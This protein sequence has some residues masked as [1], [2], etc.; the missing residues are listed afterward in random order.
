MIK[1]APPGNNTKPTSAGQ[2]NGHTTI[3]HEEQEKLDREKSILRGDV[4]K[5]YEAR[6]EREKQMREKQKKMALAAEVNT[7]V[8]RESS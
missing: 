4:V 5:K 2:Q 8:P 6:A 1:K 7:M 3:C